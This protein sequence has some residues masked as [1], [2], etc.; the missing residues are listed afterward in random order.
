MYVCEQET[1][2]AVADVDGELPSDLHRD[3]HLPSSML[4]KAVFTNSLYLS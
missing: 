1:E 3:V 2:V 4:S